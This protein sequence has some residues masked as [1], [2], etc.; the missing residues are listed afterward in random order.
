MQLGNPGHPVACSRRQNTR[1]Y[2]GRNPMGGAASS[3]RLK[4][5]E[6]ERTAHDG[7]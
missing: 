6:N 1:I 5:Q 4:E 3:L 7:L 2:P